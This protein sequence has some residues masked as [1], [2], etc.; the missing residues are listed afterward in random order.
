MR[1]YRGRKTQ[2]LIFP[3]GG[4]GTGSIGMAGN[5]RFCDW[6]IFNKPDKG[7][8]NEYT[9][10]AVKATDA[11]GH[12]DARVLQGDETKAL[13]GQYMTSYYRGYGYRSKYQYKYSRY[14]GPTNVPNENGK[15]NTK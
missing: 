14:G 13:M 6:E 5:G 3:L 8:L 4:I 10:I 9:H 2:E 15:E 11:S 7:S 12:T 1:T